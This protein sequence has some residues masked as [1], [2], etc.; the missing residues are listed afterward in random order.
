MGC[1]EFK[2]YLK[3]CAFCNCDTQWY[4]MND[5]VAGISGIIDLAVARK[6]LDSQGICAQYPWYRATA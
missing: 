2:I 4:C 1:R 6:S 5:I 3:S